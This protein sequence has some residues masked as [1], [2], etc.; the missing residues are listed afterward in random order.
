MPERNTLLRAARERCE[1][2]SAPGVPLTRQELAELVNAEVF[3]AT[4]TVT[5]VDANH[6]GKW[7]RGVIGWPAARY[8]AALRAVLGAGT[9]RELGFR[10]HPRATVGHVDRKTFLT[11]ALGASVGAFAAPQVFREGGDTSDL[12][13]ALRGSTVQ[14][15]RMESSVASDQ[16]APAVDAHLRL[17]TTVVAEQAPTPTGFAVLS[18]TAGLAAWLAADRGDL[19]TARRHYIDAV[20]HAERAVHPVLV[21][22]M[23]ASLGQFAVDSGDPH[24][25][26]SLLD[27]AAQHLDVDVPD[28]AHAWLASLYAVAHATVGDRPNATAG[29]REA[30]RRADRN[31]GEARWPWVFAIDS[32][33]VARYQ[34]AAL[35]RLGD[36]APARDAFAAAGAALRAPKPRALAETDHARV[37]AESGELAEGCRI[38][39]EALAVGRQ[40]GSERIIGRIRD[41]R[42]TLPHRTTETRELDD[43]LAA[44]YRDPAR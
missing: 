43:A 10:R 7:E 38:A 28:A 11:S 2:A 39:T 6:V 40:Y 4:G 30:E 25:G 41:F 3:R 32:A 5:A 23:T 9:D 13:A 12:A 37:L 44:L 35:G 31:R 17:V 15:R 29:L 16:L 42:A 27:R 14:Y 18:E 8:R 26:L 34:A 24:Q 36:H 33:K 20:Q 22:Y 21:C 19:A 1:S